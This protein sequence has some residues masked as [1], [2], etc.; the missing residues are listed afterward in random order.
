MPFHEGSTVKPET[1]Y[2]KRDVGNDQNDV[3]RLASKI[4]NNDIDFITTLNKE[5][6]IWDMRRK[7]PHRNKDGS[8]DYACGLNS[9]YHKPFLKNL[10]IKTDE[11]IIK[12][13]YEVY[14]NRPTAFYGYYLR[15]NDYNK[16]YLLI[17]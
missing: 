17:Q 9:Y 1:V 11:E 3:V 2:V 7:H 10:E 13:C 8:W 4:S 6:G 12:Y 14:K 16:F 15:K 5:N